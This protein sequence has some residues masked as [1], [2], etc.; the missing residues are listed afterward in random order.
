MYKVLVI[1]NYDSFTYNLVHYLEALNCSVK[2]LRNDEL[3]H[4]IIDSY[5]KV[6]ISPGSGLPNEAGKLIDFLKAYKNKKSI[7]GIC[8]GQ[9]AIAEV[10]GGELAPLKEVNHGITSML[11][12]LNNDLIYQNIPTSFQAGL[13]HSWKTINLPKNLITTA[14]SESGISMSIKHSEYNIRALQYHPESIMTPFGKQI[15]KNWLCI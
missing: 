15:L 1:D 7:L 13:Y 14:Y 2:T 9:Q 8:L 12:H 10:F 3:D 4:A 11:T 6:I 5:H